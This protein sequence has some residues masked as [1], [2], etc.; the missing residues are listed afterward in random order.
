M[1][2]WWFIDCN[3]NPC[4]MMSMDGPLFYLIFNHE[5]CTTRHRVNEMRGIC[6]DHDHDDDGHGWK[7]NKLQIPFSSSQQQHE[8]QKKSEVLL[9]IPPL[10]FTHKVEIH[11]ICV[12]IK[13]NPLSKYQYTFELWWKF[14]CKLEELFL[15]RDLSLRTSE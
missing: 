5:T 13:Q 10:Y 15:L 12:S 6:N 1:L 14:T 7:T 9:L 8:Y 11:D 4:T 2:L 3:A